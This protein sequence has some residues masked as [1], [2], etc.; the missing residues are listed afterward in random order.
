MYLFLASY[1]RL[2]LS[3]FWDV[4]GPPHTALGYEDGAL[5]LIDFV[6]LA[7]WKML[8]FRGFQNAYKWF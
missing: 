6:F 3:A 1:I 7:F 8:G 2:I 5:L 4:L